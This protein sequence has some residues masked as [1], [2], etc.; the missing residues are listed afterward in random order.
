MYVTGDAIN[1]TLSFIRNKAEK[2]SI[3]AFDYLYLSVIRNEWTYYGA[4][5]IAAV[6]KAGGESFT[7]GIEEGKIEEFL[8]DRG[9]TLK[10]HYSP[11]EFEKKYLYNGKGEFLGKMYGFAC[12]VVASNEP[13]NTYNLWNQRRTFSD[14]LKLHFFPDL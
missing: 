6:V 9:F 8:K 7:F 2:G 11:A 1:N 4:K 12:H 10:A 5:E 3:V 13:I 14:S